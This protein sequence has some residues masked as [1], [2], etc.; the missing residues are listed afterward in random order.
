VTA[1][2][3]PI[4]VISL[5]TQIVNGIDFTNTFPFYAG[6]AKMPAGSQKEPASRFPIT[7]ADIF[8]IGKGS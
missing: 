4:S 2:I 5:R 6:N 1:A 3:S 7:H 8:C